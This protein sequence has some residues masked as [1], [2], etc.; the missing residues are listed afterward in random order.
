MPTITLTAL[1]PLFPLA[2]CLA[3]SL[4]SL[5]AC[6]NSLQDKLDVAIAKA[7]A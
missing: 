3:V 7:S 6:L 1:S 5:T 4:N 2:Y